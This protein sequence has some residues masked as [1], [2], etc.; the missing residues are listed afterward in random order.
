[1]TKDK[2]KSTVKPRE[3]R[4]TL[5]LSIPCDNKALEEAILQWARTRFNVELDKVEA[6][7]NHCWELAF[8]FYSE[9]KESGK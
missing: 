1:M 6:H 7:G 3:K 8:Q 5:E 9:D 4:F 2:Q